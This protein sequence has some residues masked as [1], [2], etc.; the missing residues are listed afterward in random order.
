MSR[1]AQPETRPPSPSALY[2]SIIVALALAIRVLFSYPFVITPA[3]VNFQ[4]T[5]SW[6]HMRVVDHLIANWPHG[7]Q[8]E[9]YAMAGGRVVP[10]APLFDVVVSGAALAGG[11]GSPSPHTVEVVS[12]WV[13]AILGALIPIPVFLAGRRL[14]GDR[15][16][17]LG[18]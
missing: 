14:F 13:P 12:A 7:L 1:A 16:G 3:R 4:D 6:Y 11:L 2:L 15:A 17:L 5:D 10:L 8:T 18:A 9:P